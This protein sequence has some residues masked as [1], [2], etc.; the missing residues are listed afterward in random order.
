MKVDLPACG[1]EASLRPGV[2]PAS[3]G[4]QGSSSLGFLA[5]LTGELQ[6]PACQMYDFNGEWGGP[7]AWTD[8][9][10][11][12]ALLEEPADPGDEQVLSDRGVIAVLIPETLIM[13]LPAGEILAEG[14]AAAAVAPAGL[15][16]EAPGLLL[17]PDEGANPFELPARSY[18]E[19]AE[20]EALDVKPNGAQNQAVRPS[21]SDLLPIDPDYS[22]PLPVELKT[23]PQ[24]FEPGSSHQVRTLTR[25][26]LNAGLER[27]VSEKL[28]AVNQEHGAAIDQG[29]NAGPT[30]PVSSGTEGRQASRDPG[31]GEFLPAKVPLEITE[32]EVLKAG[33][34]GSCPAFEDVLFRIA[35]EVNGTAP[36]ENL[37]G[38]D[39]VNGNLLD[40]LQSRFIYL[41]ENGDFPAEI[42]IRL[43]PPRLGEVLIRVVSRQGRLSAEI[44]TEIAAVKD[45]L[46]LN[47]G[48]LQQRLDQIHLHLD[49]IDLLTAGELPSGAGH[50]SEGSFQREQAGGRS[51]KADSREEA[52]S[53][54]GRATADGHQ[55]VVNYWA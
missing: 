29:V 13:P 46:S 28:P 26:E 30:A 51:V 41:R 40:Q 21:G 44:V 9:Q 55:G 7:A 48:E 43:D 16:L 39:R 54:P 45:M 31:W 8:G 10:E 33:A 25:Q 35:P 47:I 50:F 23:G 12:P 4:D 37:T 19:A 18:R 49:R 42:R 3:S 2:A 38:S 15:G 36:G 27:E 17:L 53:C 22:P 11:E 1:M 5:V 24:P 6:R 14:E 32:T 34:G 52:L 20:Q